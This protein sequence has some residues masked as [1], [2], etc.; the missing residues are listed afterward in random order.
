[1]LPASPSLTL[2][3]TE[4]ERG[5]KR[6]ILRLVKGG[7]ER[8]AIEAGQIDAII[9]PAS[10]NAILLPE[11]QW[12]LNERKA[13]ALAR[14]SNRFARAILDALDA[15]IV[16]LDDAGIVLST[17]QAWRVFAAVH[18]GIG[19]GITQGSNYLAVCETAGGNEHVDGVAIG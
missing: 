15:P 17:N 6:A 8:L 14:N 10:G 11:A 2:S 5:F 3:G 4:A 9:D 18:S 16:V 19:S 12:A 13:E 7:A 1:M